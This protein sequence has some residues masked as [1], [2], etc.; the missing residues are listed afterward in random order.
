MESML[1]VRDLW[2]FIDGKETKLEEII[3]IVLL[4]AYE[5]KERCT[6]NV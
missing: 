3:T 1:K 4:A 6:V 2:G 5:K